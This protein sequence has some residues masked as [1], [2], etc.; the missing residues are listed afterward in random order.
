[1]ITIALPKG[2]LLEEAD[3]LFQK[4]GIKIGDIGSSRK[5]IHYTRDK[6]Y[7]L[8]VIRA[9][10]V[11]TF[12]EHGGAD[13]GIAGKDLLI[14]EA[15]ELYQPIDLR[16]GFCRLVVAEPEAKKG[17]LN[18]KAFV[19]IATKYPNI[20]EKHFAKKGVHVET[21]KLY[22][23]IELAPLVGMADGIVDLVSTGKTLRENKL[24]EVETILESTARLVINRASLKTRYGEI[25]RL[26]EG[27]KRGLGAG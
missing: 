21:I 20:T 12:V 18:R 13:A 8:L 24:I 16:F 22:G 2:R 6:K 1:M 17:E 23:S 27:I 14:E 5:L 11:A 7:R 19:R 10:D 26:I 15:V 9:R 25:T 4:V 3:K